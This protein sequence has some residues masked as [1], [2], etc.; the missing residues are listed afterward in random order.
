MPGA[1]KFKMKM[2]GGGGGGS[3]ATY[4]GSKHLYQNIHKVGTMM[5]L[6]IFICLQEIN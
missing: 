5:A 3:T 6:G 2:R 4:S 1:K